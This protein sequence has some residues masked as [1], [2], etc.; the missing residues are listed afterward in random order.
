MNSEREAKG[1][2]L[3][4]PT[5]PESLLPAHASS[6]SINELTDREKK[7]EEEVEALKARV[8]ALEITVDRLVEERER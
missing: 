3:S 4:T 1:D 5:P 8:K 7:L 6:A 2:P